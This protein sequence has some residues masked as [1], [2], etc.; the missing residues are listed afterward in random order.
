MLGALNM[1]GAL[2]VMNKSLEIEKCNVAFCE[3]DG[4][5]AFDMF[6]EKTGQPCGSIDDTEIPI[7]PHHFRKAIVDLAYEI[8]KENITD[9]QE[10]DINGQ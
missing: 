4:Y 7:C 5:T 8:K 2:S 6:D 9:G 10:G 1:V 3:Q